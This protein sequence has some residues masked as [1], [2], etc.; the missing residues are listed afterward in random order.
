A[1]SDLRTDGHNIMLYRET[2]ATLH[3]E[4][5]VQVTRAFESSGAVVASTLPAGRTA[6]TTHRG[7]I[8]GLALAHR[9]VLDWCAA[10][11]LRRTGTRWEIYGDWRE[12]P[13]ELETEVYWMLA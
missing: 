8:A 3:V 1:A 13:S 10:E 9:A 12:D 4:A 7:P 6:M 11:G 2:G 5:G